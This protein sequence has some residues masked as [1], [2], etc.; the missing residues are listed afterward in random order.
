MSTWVLIREIHF[1]ETLWLMNLFSIILDSVVCGFSHGDTLQTHIT[2]VV[3]ILCQ[4]HKTEV[5]TCVE[6]G[7]I[8]IPIKNVIKC[9]KSIKRQISYLAGHE[10]CSG[11]NKPAAAKSTTR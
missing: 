1:K 7:K 4:G 10:A 2:I 5:K 11:A 6:C 3:I 8:F 9:L